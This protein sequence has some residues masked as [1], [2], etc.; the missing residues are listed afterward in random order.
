MRKIKDVVSID[1][2]ETRN[3]GA[4]IVNRRTNVIGKHNYAVLSYMN[5]STSTLPKDLK[6]DGFLIGDLGG[7][8][9]EFFIPVKSTLLKLINFFVS[10]GYEYSRDKLL[11]DELPLSMYL[12]KENDKALGEK[13]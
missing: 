10:L 11:N 8:E 4:C 5:N 9:D 1:Y 6:D 2:V 7:F 13:K 3:D 12:F